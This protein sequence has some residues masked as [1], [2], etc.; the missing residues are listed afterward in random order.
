MHNSTTMY[1][2]SVGNSH[3]DLLLPSYHSFL[4]SAVY[5]MSFFWGGNINPAITVSW[6]LAGHLPT[7]QWVLTILFQVRR[8]ICMPYMGSVLWL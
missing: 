7:L 4:S 1:L 8:H 5:G 2:Q 6:A 3:P